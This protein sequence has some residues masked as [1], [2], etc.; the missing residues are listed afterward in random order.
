MDLDQLDEGLRGRLIQAASLQTRIDKG[1]ESDRGDRA[2]LASGDVA[3]KVADD[4]LGEAVGFD[5]VCQGQCRKWWCLPPIATD[6]AFDH[7]LVGKVI[8]PPGLAVAHAS[9]IDQG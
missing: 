5:L 7:A 4:P 8:E 3:E 1:I 9:R 2:W 6:D